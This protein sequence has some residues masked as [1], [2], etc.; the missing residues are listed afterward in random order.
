MT[1]KVSLILAGEDF[2]NNLTRKD[3][4]VPHKMKTM[5]MIVLREKGKKLSK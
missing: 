2:K 4:K 3:K 1:K 5:M